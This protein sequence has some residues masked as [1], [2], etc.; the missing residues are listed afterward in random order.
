MIILRMSLQS[1]KRITDFVI[2]CNEYKIISKCEQSTHL[3]Q[4]AS[5]FR[6]FAL[7][8]YLYS[9]SR[10]IAESWL[11]DVLRS[12]LFLPKILMID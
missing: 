9:F 1:F 4:T 11:C 12:V 8:Q 2:Y 10:F 6:A 3:I 7:L 5:C